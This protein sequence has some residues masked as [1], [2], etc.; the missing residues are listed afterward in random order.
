MTHLDLAAIEAERDR[1]RT[2]YLRAATEPHGTQCPVS[3][4]WLCSAQ[5]SSAPSASTRGPRAPLTE[6][7][8]SGVYKGVQPLLLRGGQRQPIST[9]ST[10]QDSHLEL[11]PRRLAGCTTW[12]SPWSPKDGAAPGDLD[13][14]GMDY[15]R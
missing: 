10:C 2:K 6:V 7:F 3:T 15:Q 5:M 13:Q 9:S 1:I 12:S 14:A 4:T 8:E 11:T